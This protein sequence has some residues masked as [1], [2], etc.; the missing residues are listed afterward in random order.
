MGMVPMDVS[1][2]LVL[3]FPDCNTMLKYT[4]SFDYFK[5]KN[6]NFHSENRNVFTEEKML[7]ADFQFNK[8]IKW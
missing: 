8:K 3:Y 2:T 7:G 1:W 6:G 5:T 4:I